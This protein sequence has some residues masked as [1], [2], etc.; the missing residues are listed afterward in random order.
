[1]GCYE[2]EHTPAFTKMELKSKT[3]SICNVWDPMDSFD[4]LFLEE[5]WT[6]QIIMCLLQS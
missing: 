1:M 4:G 2:I 6:R 3:P 5:A